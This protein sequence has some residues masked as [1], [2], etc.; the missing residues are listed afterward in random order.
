MDFLNMAWVANLGLWAAV[1]GVLTSTGYLFLLLFATVRFRLRQGR[2]KA[3]EGAMPPAT[4]MKP[5]CG[6][7]PGLE[8]HLE[9]FFLQDYPQFEILFGTRNDRDPALEVVR[10]LCAR[11]PEVRVRTV[12]SGEP[13]K[14]NAKVCT[15]RKMFRAA[16]YEHVVISD[17]DVGVEPDYLRRVIAPLLNERTGLTMCLYRGVSTGG[18]WAGLEALGM[19]VEMTAGVLAAATIG[20]VDFALGPTMATRRSVVHAIGGVGVLAEYCADD[21]VL[22]NL[23]AKSGL[24]VE[25][26]DKVIDHYV[27][28]RSFWASMQHQMRWML[29]TRFSIPA[30]HASSVLGFAVPF[31]VL[32]ALAGWMG[33]HAKLGLALLGWTI[34]N[35]M[36]MSVAV[37]WGVVRDRRALTWCWLYPVR[38][39]MGFIFW[40]G[41]YTGDTVD[42][43]GERYRLVQGGLMVR[44]GGAMLPA[45]VPEEESVVVGVDHLS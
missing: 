25:I 22:G 34:V 2:T 4:M 38:D 29:S 1:I 31:G 17:S 26:S 11:H 15:L 33:G 45:P 23:V 30:G 18:L 19:S 44:E 20:E 27:V 42:W 9:S 43:R 35:R 8:A 7:E 13:D 16:A 32:A 24:K 14:P 6:M 10:R 28:N 40:L 5:L 36:A 3:P 41:S 39:L 37:G 12:Y 21:Y